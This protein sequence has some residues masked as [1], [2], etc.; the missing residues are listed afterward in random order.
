[1]LQLVFPAV[2]EEVTVEYLP[3]KFKW[4]KKYDLRGKIDE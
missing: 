1:M 3:V 4:V 2:N